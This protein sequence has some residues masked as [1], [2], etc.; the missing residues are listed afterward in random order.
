MRPNLALTNNNITWHI[1][2]RREI[3][4]GSYPTLPNHKIQ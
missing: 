1:T 3:A 2:Q 4:F